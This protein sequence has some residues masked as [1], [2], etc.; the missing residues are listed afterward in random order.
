MLSEVCNSVDST[1]IETACL[2]CM[3]TISGIELSVN[4]AF[5]F[6]TDLNAG[7]GLCDR[8]ASEDNF[9]Y[10]RLFSAEQYIFYVPRESRVG[11]INAD[12]Y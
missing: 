11:E 10:I 12:I 7:L 6:L 9:F 3:N 4:L 2:M 8:G 1:V 5:I